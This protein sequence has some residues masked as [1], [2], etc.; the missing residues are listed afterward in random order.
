[1]NPALRRA[2]RR[3]RELL[4][5]DPRF[6][7]IVLRATPLG[8]SRA[9]TS[10]TQIVIEGFPRS[11]N[12]F[13]VFAL[14]HAEA[15]HGREVAISSH[16]H[17]PAQVKLAVGRRVPTLLVVREPV[18]AVASLLVAAPHVRPA[19]ALREWS[20]HHR[21]LLPWRGGFVVGGFDEVTGDFGAVTAAVNARFGTD[22]AIFEATPENLQAV[23]E[24]V[25]AHY[26]ATYGGRASE[27]VVPRPSAARRADS[28]RVQ[29]VLASDALAELVA[30]AR[31]VY[32]ELLAGV[33]GAAT[34]E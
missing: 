16:V 2:L 31:A 21:E 3:A 19:A 10:S 34:P 15:Q 5:D 29:E 30:D 23:I 4:G 28:A 13:A 20:H 6:L 33:R 11:G 24:A 25:D 32:A 18:D 27:R 17:V 12:T 26:A 14:K 8:T 22:F 9:I 1:M 7:P